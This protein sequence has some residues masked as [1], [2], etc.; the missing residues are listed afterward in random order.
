MKMI[1]NK[2]EKMAVCVLMI[3]KNGNVLSVS[4][5]GVYDQVG[6]PGGKV[7]LDDATILDT[8]FRELS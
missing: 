1:G 3:T 7:D 6:L 5:K 4:R 2:M 8:A